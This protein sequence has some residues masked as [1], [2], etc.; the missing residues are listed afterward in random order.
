MR[1][2]GASLADQ[3][4]DGSPCRST[5]DSAPGSTPETF[6]GRAPF[7]STN[8]VRVCARLPLHPCEREYDN[9]K[10]VRYVRFRTL[11][12]IGMTCVQGDEEPFRSRRSLAVARLF[13]RDYTC[14]VSPGQ[15]M[16]DPGA[17]GRLQQ[18]RVSN[19]GC[20]PRGSGCSRRLLGRTRCCQPLLYPFS[21]QLPRLRRPVG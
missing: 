16:R 5:V 21:R 7:E 9:D 6:S 11:A 19:T 17:G 15:M 14:F 10:P 2:I 18:Y 1:R 20:P 12:E 8:R 4:E 13:G 3:R